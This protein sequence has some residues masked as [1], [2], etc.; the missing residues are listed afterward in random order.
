MKSLLL[1]GRSHVNPKAKEKLK[2][3]LLSGADHQPAVAASFPCQSGYPKEV[4]LGESLSSACIWPRR[5]SLSTTVRLLHGS[6]LYMG[7]RR[8]GI[9]H[10]TPFTNLLLASPALLGLLVGAL[11]IR[12]ALFGGLVSPFGFVL[13][14]FAF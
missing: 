10:S 5:F 7:G 6:R 9:C 4:W 2:E 8:L 12:W 1:F 3:S 11:R 14:G 13:R